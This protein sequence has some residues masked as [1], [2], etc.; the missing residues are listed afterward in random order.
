MAVENLNSTPIGNIEAT[1]KVFNNSNVEGG[2]LRSSVA[3][4]EASASASATST[5]MMVKVPSNARIRDVIFS[6]DAM[7]ATGAVDVGIY[8]TEENGGAV[9]DA[10]HFASAVANTSAVTNSNVTHES[11]VNGIEDKAKPLW[12]ALGLSAD[13]K[14]DYYVGLTATAVLADGGTMALDVSYVI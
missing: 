13:P 14:R 4:V 1:P 9:V 5:Y 6:S 2:H 10:D 12:E 3:I 8:Q 7:G 11:G